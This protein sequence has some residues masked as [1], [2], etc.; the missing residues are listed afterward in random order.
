[1]INTDRHNYTEMVAIDVSSADQIFDYN[2]TLRAMLVSG[3]GDLDVTDIE[4]NRDVILFE[5][6]ANGGVYPFLLPLQIKTVHMTTT[7]IT[8]SSLIGLR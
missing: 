3:A 6:A 8:N 2:E 5:T 4:G 1:M 7:T